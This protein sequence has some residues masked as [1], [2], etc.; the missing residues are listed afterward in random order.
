MMFPDGI[1]QL[2]NQ[3]VLGIDPSSKKLACVQFTSAGFERCEIMLAKTK[4]AKFTHMNTAVA[5]RDFGAWI[6]K[7]SDPD[8]TLLCLEA[9]VLGGHMGI[10]S[11]LPQIRVSGAVAGVAAG[12]GITE[13]I[14]VAPS[15]WKKT[16]VGHGHATKPQIM[17]YV[18]QAWPQHFTAMTTFGN[19]GPTEDLC[20][21]FC[22]ALYGCVQLVGESIL[23][24]F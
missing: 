24:P 10:Q 19:L 3:A 22:I 18:M 9:P 13:C 12:Y 4:S 21:A 23:N 20:D 14:D 17:Q 7:F 2:R 8:N 6:R 15:S 11:W 1:P 5:I 16:V